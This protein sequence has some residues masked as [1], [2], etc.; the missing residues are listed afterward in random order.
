MQNWRLAPCR[1]IS[2]VF[3]T[4]FHASGAM[5]LEHLFETSRDDPLLP[6]AQ[7]KRIHGERNT[8]ILFLQQHRRLP[9]LQKLKAASVVSENFRGSHSIRMWGT[10]LAISGI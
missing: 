5:K 7:H 1:L 10:W 4:N 3:P 2:S 9:A 8:I 6:R